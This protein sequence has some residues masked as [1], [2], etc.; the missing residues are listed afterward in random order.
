MP[1]GGCG[2]RTTDL[3][4]LGISFAALSMSFAFFRSAGERDWVGSSRLRC[5][6]QLWV[7]SGRCRCRPYLLTSAMEMPTS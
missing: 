5:A 2:R 1:P 3:I 6:G 7:R 4:L